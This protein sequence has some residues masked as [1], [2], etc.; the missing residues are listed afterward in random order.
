M[1]KQFFKLIVF[2]L[3]IFCMSSVYAQ[4]NP[5]EL[6]ETG[7][8]VHVFEGR[9]AVA[10]LDTAVRV[11][12]ARDSMSLSVKVGQ[13]NP[14]EV[15]ETGQV[16]AKE[17]PKAKRRAPL[18]KEPLFYEVKP[19]DRSVLHPLLVVLALG[20]VA[21]FAYINTVFKTELGKRLQGVLNTNLIGLFYREDRGMF[22][23]A[24][25]LLQ[26]LFVMSFGTFLYALCS[27]YQVLPSSYSVGKGLLVFMLAAVG[28]VLFRNVTL[29]LLGGI[30][31]FSKEVDMYRYV[32]NFFN[33]IIGIGLI[34]FV[35]VLLFAPMGFKQVSVYV[36][37]GLLVLAYVVRALRGLSVA[38]GRVWSY[39]LH[40][41]LYVCT[42]EVAPILILVKLILNF[43]K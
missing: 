4:S 23:G 6:D 43:Q 17:K 15:W 9:V 39:P 14:F 20:L 24:N 2:G 29:S 36:G 25:L 40:F 37:L 31:P 21:L 19:S 26:V 28:T 30:Y 8:P 38:G 1:N 12:G 3:F 41:M 18:L 35:I 13:Q 33:Q 11:S 42:V 22:V 16:V 32:I 7:K 5:F 10:V 34:P 27:Y